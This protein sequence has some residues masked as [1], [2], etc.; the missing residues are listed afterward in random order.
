MTNNDSRDTLKT[1]FI[2][3]TKYLYNDALIDGAGYSHNPIP[4]TGKPRGFI[5]AGTTEIYTQLDFVTAPYVVLKLETIEAAYERE[6]HNVPPN[7]MFD[8]DDILVNDGGKLKIVL[9]VINGVQQ[10]IPFDGV[11]AVT[12]YNNREA[13]RQ[14][15]SKVL[16]PKADL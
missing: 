4:I 10:A 2:N 5:I 9:P 11:W 16:K 8:Y 7:P 6:V 1:G 13:Q 12:L 14:S 3:N 15:I